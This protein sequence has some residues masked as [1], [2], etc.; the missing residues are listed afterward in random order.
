MKL[1]RILAG[2]LVCALNVAMAGCNSTGST[3]ASS[4]AMS[5]AA[6]INT[7]NAALTSPAAQQA[8]AN[9]KAL[10][11][12]IACS[13]AGQAAQAQTLNTALKPYVSARQA[14]LITD[15]NNVQA[16]V[17]VVNASI[18]SQLGGVIGN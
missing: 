11:M 16:I 7:I 6:D 1:N 4:A 8:I 18:C 2:A 17:Y 15:I 9:A 10:G 12:T 13:V 5:L 3:G 14:A